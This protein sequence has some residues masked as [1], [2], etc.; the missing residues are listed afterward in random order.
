MSLGL[1]NLNNKDDLEKLSKEELV[2][3]VIAQ[4]KEIKEFADKIINFSE[5]E[6]LEYQKEL[7]AIAEAAKV[8][9]AIS[10]VQNV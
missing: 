3:L 4:S 2:N 5:E 9:I 6:L 8:F 7:K 10:G 1:I